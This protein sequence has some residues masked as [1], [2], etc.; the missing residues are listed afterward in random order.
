MAEDE[1]EVALAQTRLRD[2]L[3]A[4]YSLAIKAAVEGNWI[5]PPGRASAAQVYCAVFPKRPAGTW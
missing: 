5:R 3:L 4:E 2:K 1:E